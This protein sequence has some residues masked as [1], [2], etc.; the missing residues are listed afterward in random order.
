MDAL[1]VQGTDLL[2]VSALAIVGMAYGLGYR[3]DWSEEAGRPE[4]DQEIAEIKAPAAMSKT[5]AFAPPPEAA[6]PLLVPPPTPAV[7]SIGPGAAATPAP[8]SADVQWENMIREMDNM[9]TRYPGRVSI[10]LKDLKSG[11]TWMYHPDDLFPAASLIKVP[12]M[13]ATFYKIREGQLALDEKLA[14]SRRNRVGGS[15][16]LKWR[17]DGTKLTMRELLVHMI[18]E[19]DNTATK[20]VLDR[21]GIGFVQQQFPRMGLLYTGIYEEGMSIK[22]GR[23]MH[24][25]YT[26]AREMSLL[27]E[28]I[29]K[30]NA[31]DKLSSEIM[32][33]ILKKPKAVA[34]RL[35]KGMP[36]G[37]EIAH[38]TGLLR[39]ACHD[40]AIFLSP[41]GDYAI[42]VLTGQNRSYS[43]AKDFITKL[44]KVTFKNYAGPNYYAKATPRRRTRVIR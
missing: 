20:M 36:P 22:G 42:T 18:N 37:W 8:N 29:Y 17:Q 34:S 3:L 24:E 30:G 10:Y 21:L 6:A 28:N 27:M 38:K 14:I 13:I 26:T 39:Q 11:K 23:V 5:V 40:S 9:A 19:S 7:V 1:R 44:A 12:V 33:D 43:Q 16:S 35:A 31:V 2:L 4:E 32:L 25:N 41:N 15:G